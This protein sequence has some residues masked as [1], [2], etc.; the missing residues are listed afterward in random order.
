MI[1]CRQVAN[2]AFGR[3]LSVLLIAAAWLAGC[4]SDPNQ[5][6]LRFVSSGAKYFSEHKYQEAIIQFRGAVQID[7]KFAAAHY[8]LAQAYLAAG[9]PAA[10]FREFYQTVDL[11]PANLDAKLNLAKLLIDNRQI[12]EGQMIA[13]AVIKVDPGNASGHAILGQ[14][15]MLMH[16]F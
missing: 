10:A 1:L 14:T 5:K 3:R 6:K 4:S 15:Y 2:S 7:P 8:Q 13:Q 16:D 12:R 9:N 11:D